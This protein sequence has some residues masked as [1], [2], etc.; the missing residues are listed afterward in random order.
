M[1]PGNPVAFCVEC[2]PEDAAVLRATELKAAELGTAELTIA[3]L[4]AT[5]LE[6][7]VLEG[8]TAAVVLSSGEYVNMGGM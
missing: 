1:K 5:G 7:R 8:T 6:T 2:T 3:E 4:G